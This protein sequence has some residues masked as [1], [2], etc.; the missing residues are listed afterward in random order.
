MRE[1]ARVALGLAVMLAAGCAAP[2]PTPEPAAA[3]EEPERLIGVGRSGDMP[4][5]GLDVLVDARGEAGEGGRNPFRFGA[6]PPSMVTDGRG[7]RTLP[8]PSAISRDG[9]PRLEGGRAAASVALKFIGTLDGGRVGRIGVLS[10]GSFVHHGRVGDIV[11]GR[12]RI[13]RIGVE[14][15]ELEVVDGGR[16]MTIRL[17]GS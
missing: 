2:D 8:G 3:G 4:T 16:R 14:S 10:D 1:G 9:V 6:A 12:Y 7:P 17:T 11:D 13:V 5:V 15:I